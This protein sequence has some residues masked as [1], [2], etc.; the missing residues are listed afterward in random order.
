MIERFLTQSDVARAAGVDR[1]ATRDAL[2]R[3]LLKADAYAGRAAIFRPDNPTVVAYI[4]RPRKNR[5]A[6]AR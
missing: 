5:E 1:T 6:I 4:N 3:G 2:Q